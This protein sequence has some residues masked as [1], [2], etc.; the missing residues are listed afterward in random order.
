MGKKTKMSYS[1]MPFYLC[2]VYN[3]IKFLAFYFFF[4]QKKCQFVLA[5]VA[6]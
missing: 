2:K 3:I 1:D 4:T 6:Q 5:G